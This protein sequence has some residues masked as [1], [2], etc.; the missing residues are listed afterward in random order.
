MVSL[1]MFT[2]SFLLDFLNI[3]GDEFKISDATFRERL[4]ALY[5]VDIRYYKQM[6]EDLKSRYH[7]VN[8]KGLAIGIA[9]SAAALA[10]AA[11]VRFECFITFSNRCQIL[12]KNLPAKMA[13]PISRNGGFFNVIY[14]RLCIFIHGRCNRYCE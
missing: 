5:L 13:S 9:G 1:K 2:V 7:F 10:L 6:P 14:R 8:L 12:H 3:Q 4:S 11:K